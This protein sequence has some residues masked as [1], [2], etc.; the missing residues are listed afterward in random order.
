MIRTISIAIHDLGKCPAIEQS[1]VVLVQAAPDAM[2]QAPAPR[3]RPSPGQTGQ[4]VDGIENGL[5]A[6]GTWGTTRHCVR[7]RGPVQAVGGHPTSGTTATSYTI[8]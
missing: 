4:D 2:R 1:I 7:Y 6:H 3:H 8:H 5:A